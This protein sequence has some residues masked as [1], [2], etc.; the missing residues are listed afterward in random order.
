MKFID[1]ES[2][3]LIKNAIQQNKLNEIIYLIT[4]QGENLREKCKTESKA[5]LM[6]YET[7]LA[8]LLQIQFF[9]DHEISPEHLEEMQKYIGRNVREIYE[10]LHPEKKPLRRLKHLSLVVDN[11]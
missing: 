7:F 4:L 6:V 9:G 5:E 3:N 2:Q 1:T 11:T 8:L 10:I